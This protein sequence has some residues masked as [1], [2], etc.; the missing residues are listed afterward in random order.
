M[1]VQLRLPFPVQ[2]SVAHAQYCAASPVRQHMPM[3]CLPKPQESP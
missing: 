2:V 1:T 3:E